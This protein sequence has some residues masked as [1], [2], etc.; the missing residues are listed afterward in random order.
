FLSSCFGGNEKRNDAGTDVAGM[1]ALDTITVPPVRKAY[2]KFED[3][4][5]KAAYIPLETSANSMIGNISR[6]C[7][8]RDQFFILDKKGN[9]ILIFDK[10]G[11]FLDK[12][13]AIGKGPGEYISLMDFA[14]DREG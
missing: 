11:K 12:I 5:S 2:G 3:F 13:E 9:S 8:F 14:I 10:K 7:Y 1:K 4:F 6:L